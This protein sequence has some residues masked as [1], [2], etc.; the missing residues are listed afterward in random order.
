M[1]AAMMESGLE[2][3]H[4]LGAVLTGS[5]DVKTDLR[6]DSEIRTL[7]QEFD[8]SGSTIVLEIKVGLVDISNRSLLSSVTFSY[9]EPAESADPR[10]GVVAANRA[11]GRFLSDLKGFIAGAIGRFDCAGGE[12]A[13]DQGSMGPSGE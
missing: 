9:R 1:T 13:T 6:L 2:A 10:A 3:S 8:S 5:S 4:L 11:A 12:R 7:Q